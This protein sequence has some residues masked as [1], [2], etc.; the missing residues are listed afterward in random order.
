MN[1]FKL[2]SVFILLLLAACSPIVIDQ[3]PTETSVGWVWS[4]L[5]PMTWVTR[6]PDN[7]A[8]PTFTP[9]A[10]PLNLFARGQIVFQSDRD[11]GYELYLMNA[12]GSVLS[13]L[14]NN[15][16]AD[17]FP[18][19]SPDGSRIAF[20]SDREGNAEIYVVNAD[21][22]DLTRIT[23]DLSNDVLPQWSPDGGSIAFVSDRDGNEEIYVMNADGSSVRRLTN[24]NASDLFPHWSPDGE[25]IV[26]STNRDV[27]SE[28]YKMDKNGGQLMRL[29]N[30][31]AVDSDPAW[32]PDG[33]RIAF[34]SRRDGFA[35]L[36]VMNADGS[37]VTQLTFYKSIVE[38]P[39]WSPDSHMIAFSSDMEGSREIYIIGADGVG[40]NRLTDSPSFDFYPDWSPQ[41]SFLTSALPE[42]TPAPGDT[43]LVSTDPDYGYNPT[44]PVRLGFDPRTLGASSQQC[45][46]WLTGPDGQILNTELL[47]E[48]S[49][50]NSQLCM[51]R[52]FYEGQ[53][54]EAILYF[55]TFN[56]EQPLAPV[57]FTCGSSSEY[58][59]MLANARNAGF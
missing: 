56:Y 27:D 33:T 8:T 50:G 53:A 59:R 31:P 30:D 58:M 48:V 3:S 14:T 20:T 19:W 45:L 13:R 24:N 32:S 23:N 49:L 44:N 55:D 16:A 21:G 10:R 36:F 43:C 38:V 26:F 42:P 51:V 9:T 37:E 12:D 11:G 1:K 57:G 29:T 40:L 5:T 18:D 39:S 52:V 28:I 54:E 22:T 6:A 15:P 7:I 4:T 46:P 17:I 47:E 25:W 41:L 34:I 2:I 35:N